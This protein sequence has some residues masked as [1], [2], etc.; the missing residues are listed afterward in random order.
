MRRPPFISSLSFEGEPI[1]L[2]LT[3]MHV[4]I[5]IHSGVVVHMCG[6]EGL[7]R[8]VSNRIT[9]FVVTRCD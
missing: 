4:T 1:E 9:E 2:V 6:D 7:S 5:C 8:K 3:Y